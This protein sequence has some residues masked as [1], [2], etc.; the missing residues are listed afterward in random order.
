MSGLFESCKYPRSGLASAHFPAYILRGANLQGQL[1]SLCAVI[2]GNH[3]TST[4]KR[5]VVELLL[6]CQ[7]RLDLDIAQSSHAKMT[8]SLLALS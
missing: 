4:H 3:V 5:L 2:L 8:G 6:S 7:Q 1:G